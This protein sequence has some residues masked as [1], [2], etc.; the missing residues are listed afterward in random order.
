[1]AKVTDSQGVV[2][3]YI[4][5]I[6]NILDASGATQAIQSGLTSFME[7]IP[8]LM[9]ALDEVARIHPVVTGAL[10]LH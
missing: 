5:P 3:K 6:K 8:W 4:A 1:M 9:K 10:L 2:A 7:D